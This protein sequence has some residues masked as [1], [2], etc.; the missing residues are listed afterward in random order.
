MSVSSKRKEFAPLKVFFLQE[1]TSIRRAIYVR[2]R[3]VPHSSP[4]PPHPLPPPFVKIGEEHGV[5]PIN[6]IAPK[7]MAN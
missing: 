5:I 1:L 3:Q 7:G 2:S 4:P 6:L